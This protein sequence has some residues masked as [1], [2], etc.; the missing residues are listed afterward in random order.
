[1]VWKNLKNKPTRPFMGKR[2]ATDGSARAS[3]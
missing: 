1:M 3:L 2:K